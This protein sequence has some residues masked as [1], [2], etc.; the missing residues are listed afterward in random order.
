MF[1]FLLIYLL[2]FIVNLIYNNPFPK[3]LDFSEVNL[4]DLLQIAASI[5]L[6]AAAVTATIITSKNANKINKESIK[7]NKQSVELSRNALTYTQETTDLQINISLFQQRI[8]VLHTIDKAIHAKKKDKFDF[9]ILYSIIE[10]AYYLFPPKI[11]LKILKLSEAILDYNNKYGKRERKALHYVEKYSD[12]TTIQS[13]SDNK[14]IQVLRA[15]TLEYETIN[16]HCKG[17]LNII[18]QYSKCGYPT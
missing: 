8:H 1:L 2:L 18:E 14:E 13:F 17:L 10:T 7:L 3:L 12:D 16:K 5:I 6:G 4:F 11:A 9:D 15:F